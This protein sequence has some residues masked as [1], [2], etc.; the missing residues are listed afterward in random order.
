MLGT[1]RL[2]RSCWEPL[3]PRGPHSR[4]VQ[5]QWREHSQRAVEKAGELAKVVSERDLWWNQQR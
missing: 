1:R 5:L 4:A 3:L 2:G